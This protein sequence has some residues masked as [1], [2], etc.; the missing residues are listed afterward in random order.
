MALEMVPVLLAGLLALAFAGYLA[1]YILRQDAGTDR[2]RE[3]AAAIQEGASTF[4]RDEF[5]VL[6][7]VTIIITV[8]FSLLLDPKPW[9][10]IAYLVGTITSA[11]AGYM[12][13]SI[14]VRANSRTA[15]AAI[16][17][18]SQALRVAFSGGAVMGFCVVGLGLLG[19]AIIVII[20]DDS[21]VWLGY[22]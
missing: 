9:V 12:G 2:V 14:A 21:H 13:M 7:F 18:W 5:R 11:L 19:L 15:T 4:L 1:L 16:S 20:F 10:G 6:A 22:A 3:I 8:I 17:S